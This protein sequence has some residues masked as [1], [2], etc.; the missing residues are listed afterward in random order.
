MPSVSN[1]GGSLTSAVLLTLLAWGVRWIRGELIRRKK[2]EAAQRQE[3]GSPGRFHSTLSPAALRMLVETGAQPHIIFDVRRTDDTQ[4]L[5][6]ELR[7]A[8]RLPSDAV[9]QGLASPS[10]WAELFQGVSYPEPHFMLVFVGSTAEQQ[11]SA[12]VAAASC[13]YQ[14]TMTLEGA[15]TDFA[16]GAAT[17]RHLRFISRDA[18]AALLNAPQG[19]FPR[20]FVIDVRRSDERALYG[21]I[22]GT[23]HIPGERKTERALPAAAAVRSR[24]ALGLGLGFV[25][26]RTTY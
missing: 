10:A 26:W 17:Q 15:L 9:S 7:G 23:V 21:S 5:P 25:Q 13:G 12:A 18:V 22:K 2:E 16:S 24:R 4:P 19:I 11:F 1:A 8:L 20:S 3:Q 14:R 6:S